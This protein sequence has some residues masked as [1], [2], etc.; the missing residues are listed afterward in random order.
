MLSNG[1]EILRVE[2]EPFRDKFPVSQRLLHVLEDFEIGLCTRHLWK[3]DSIGLVRV[4]QRLVL[5][6]FAEILAK[7][8]LC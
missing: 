3:R 7:I 8:H 1:W 2:L 5:V 6:D 4:V